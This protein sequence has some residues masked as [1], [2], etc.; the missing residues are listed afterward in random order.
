VKKAVTKVGRGKAG[1]IR[2]T[3]APVHDDHDTRFGLVD[4]MMIVALI[5]GTVAI[6]RLLL[7][8]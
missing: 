2:N 6:A 3:I 1:F 5:G 8:H 7:A 4:V